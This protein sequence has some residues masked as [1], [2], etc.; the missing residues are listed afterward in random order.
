MSFRTAEDR[1]ADWRWRINTLYKI[2]DKLGRLRP[3]REN[4]VQKLINDNDSKRKMILKYRQGGVTTNEVIKQLDFTLW[5][6]NINACILAHDR[7]GVEKIF[8]IPKLAYDRMDPF[9][10]PAI[11]RGGGSKYEMRFPGL[12]SKI[13]CDIESRGDTIHWLH[14]SEA[15]FADPNRIKATLETVPPNGRVTFETTPNGMGNHFY[16]MWIHKSQRTAKLFFPWFYHGEYELPA[17]QVKLT[18]EEDDFFRD[19]KSVV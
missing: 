8:R 12:N 3:L 2:T 6:K 17:D 15:A 18:P 7:K 1:L 16:R 19:R 9:I 5:H 10:K 11:D 13:Y 4:S 14:I